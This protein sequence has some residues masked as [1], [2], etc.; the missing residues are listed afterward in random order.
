M[1]LLYLGIVYA[2]KIY[3]ILYLKG[4][5]Y[6]KQPFKALEYCRRK[7]GR[8]GAKVDQTLLARSR[9]QLY[10]D[11]FQTSQGHLLISIMQMLSHEY[12]D[13]GSFHYSTSDDSDWGLVWS[14][15]T[16]GFAM[17]GPFFFYLYGLTSIP[18]WISNPMI[19]K[20][21]Y[22]IDYPFPNLNVCTVEI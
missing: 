4:L 10:F 20:V 9:P 11:N 1:L 3:Y 21:W 22:E 18:A 15:P 7:K 16:A 2:I 6:T 12:G 17:Q 8:E 13:D 5:N 19:S 14:R